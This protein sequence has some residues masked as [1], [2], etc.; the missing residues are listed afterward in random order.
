MKPLL[1]AEAFSAQ[2]RDGAKPG[3]GRPTAQ[4]GPVGLADVACRD[5]LPSP[6][7]PHPTMPAPAHR[8]GS[9]ERPLAR[10][11]GKPNS[12]S[13]TDRGHVAKVGSS[14]L[15]RDLGVGPSLAGYT[16]YDVP[17]HGDTLR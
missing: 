15:L 12:P 16:L 13:V 5:P 17:S 7:S 6:A 10:A 2:G 4:R 8:Y 1:E 9:N 11:G 14:V 3:R